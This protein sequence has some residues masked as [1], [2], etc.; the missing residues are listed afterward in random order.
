MMKKHLH[1]N[2]SAESILEMIAE[3][4][5]NA[6]TKGIEDHF[7]CEESYR[8]IIK[9]DSSELHD[10]IKDH[11]HGTVESKLLDITKL[12]NAYFDARE[13]DKEV[14]MIMVDKSRE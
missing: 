8:K 11:L 3:I 6:M 13:M 4:A 5:H 14:L 7:L 9:A 12:I 10:L 2:L 1:V